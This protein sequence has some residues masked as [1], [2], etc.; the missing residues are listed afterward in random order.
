MRTVT[1]LKNY[2]ESYGITKESV[3]AVIETNRAFFDQ[4]IEWGKNDSE[5]ILSPK[6]L[7]ELGK[8]FNENNES[9]LSLPFKVNEQGKMEIFM[10]SPEGETETEDVKK[11]AEK[12]EEKPK[13]IR[14]KRSKYRATKQ[15]IAENGMISLDNSDD[16]KQIRRFLMNDGTHKAEEVALLTDK[17]VQDE[18][19]KKY[20]I[21]SSDSCMYIIARSVLLDNLSDIYVLGKNE[22]KPEGAE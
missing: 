5:T 1:S 10:P 8:H 14:L 20:F 21:I 3:M 11:E 18:L 12:T 4:Y 13:K 7:E 6:A 16:M 2:I 17:E 19:I 9:E 15:F 22:E